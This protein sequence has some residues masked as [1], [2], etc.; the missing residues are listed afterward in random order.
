[1]II[2]KDT[3][4]LAR[5]LPSLRDVPPTTKAG[6][7]QDLSHLRQARAGLLFWG[8]DACR[9][10]PLHSHSGESAPWST[11][12]F[13]KTLNTRHISLAQVSYGLKKQTIPQPPH[14]IIVDWQPVM[15]D[16][17]ALWV[18]LRA[19]GC[20][21]SMVRAQ[22]SRRNILL[23]VSSSQERPPGPSLNPALQVQSFLFTLLFS[24]IATAWLTGHCILRKKLSYGKKAHSK[25]NSPHLKYRLTDKVFIFKRMQ[26]N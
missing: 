24:C 20:L 22:S 18:R 26:L 12:R 16:T 11:T 14:S 5:T 13:V 8:T 4:W 25:R 21:R 23:P 9:C 19:A 3:S 7:A 6:P 10:H 2:R 15:I 17:G 1:M